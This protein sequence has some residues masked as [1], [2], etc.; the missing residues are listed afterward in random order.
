MLFFLFV[1]PFSSDGM[2]R[3]KER[4]EDLDV[5]LC[6]RREKAGEGFWCQVFSYR[7]DARYRK[8]ERGQREAAPQSN[9]GER[10]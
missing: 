6:V 1:F 10:K 7:K 5:L 9:R 4:R 8:E 2:K 3:E